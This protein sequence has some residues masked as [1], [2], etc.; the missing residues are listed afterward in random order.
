[1][2]KEEIIKDIKKIDEQLKKNK[3]IINAHPDASVMVLCEL[4][5]LLIK[6]REM[7]QDMLLKHYGV[8]YMRG[9]N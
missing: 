8:F 4:S 1:M 6:T 7:L 5:K 9:S 3:E 2:S